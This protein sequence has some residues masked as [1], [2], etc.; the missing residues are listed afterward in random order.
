MVV[1]LSAVALPFTAPYASLMLVNVAAVRFANRKWLSASSTCTTVP[2]YLE[3][4]KKLMIL[5]LA[6]GH[7]PEPDEY[8][9][10]Y[11]ELSAS[12]KI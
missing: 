11:L 10:K 8:S 12:W 1:V 6:L 7:L 5:E 3:Q 2:E 4:L 9:R